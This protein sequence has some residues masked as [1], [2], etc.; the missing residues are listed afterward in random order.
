[1]G[2][3]VEFTYPGQG[4]NNGF[5]VRVTIYN[6]KINSSNK[7]TVFEK[8]IPIENVPPSISL[9]NPPVEAK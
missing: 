4:R 7:L 5:T 2:P 6:G 9:V 1:M 3:N 8:F